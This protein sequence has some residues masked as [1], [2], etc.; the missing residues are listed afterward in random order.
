M[1]FSEGRAGAAVRQP[2][3]AAIVMLN[4]YPKGISEAIELLIQ[5]GL[6]AGVGIE[7]ACTISQAAAHL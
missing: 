6:E 1:A 4:T 7:P 3:Q 5:L 2:T